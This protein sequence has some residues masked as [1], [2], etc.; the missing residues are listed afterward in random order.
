MEA[1]G[2][3]L[4][5]CDPNYQVFFHDNE[6]MTLSSDLAKMKPEIEKWEGKDGF[7]RYLE[8][9]GEGH[10]HYEF[11]MAKALRRNFPSILSMTSLDL[12]KDVTRM[13]IFTSLVGHSIHQMI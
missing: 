2:V 11:S 7:Q 13:A 8:W 12:L 5:K 3:K 10:K 1:E 4:F 9:M 6:M